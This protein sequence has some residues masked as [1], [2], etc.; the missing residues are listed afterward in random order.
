MQVRIEK[1]EQQRP[2]QWKKYLRN[3]QNKL[4]NVKFLLE[5][6]S[7]TRNAHLF[8]PANF[9]ICALQIIRLI[10][11]DGLIKCVSE[12]I[13]DQEE[14]DTKAFCVL[15]TQ[16]HLESRLLVFQQC[17]SSLQY[18]R[19]FTLQILVLMYIEIGISDRRRCID[20]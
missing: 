4:D 17:I 9:F 11:K 15:S 1:R 3:D 16:K 5:D 12:L 18:T 6:W 20:I 10:L 2:K 13:C 14:A 19:F 7:M 8:P